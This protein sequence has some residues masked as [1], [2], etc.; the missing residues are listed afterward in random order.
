MFVEST[1]LPLTA[2]HPCFFP[3]VTSPP[4]SSGVQVAVTEFGGL[5]DRAG[6]VLADFVGHCRDDIVRAGVSH[7]VRAPVRQLPLA[8]LLPPA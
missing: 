8:C 6:G 1:F 2:N 5:G 3:I 7:A 4:P